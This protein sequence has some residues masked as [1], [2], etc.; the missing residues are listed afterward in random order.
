MH[1]QSIVS[2]YDAIDLSS[3]MYATIFARAH[4]EYQN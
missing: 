3:L 4:A 2:V 1:F